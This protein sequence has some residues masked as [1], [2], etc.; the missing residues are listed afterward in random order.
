MT[1]AGARD[2]AALAGS[3]L[4]MAFAALICAV[5]A[6]AI[7][8]LVPANLLAIAMLFGSS[9]FPTPSGMSPLIDW[10]VLLWLPAALLVA[11]RNAVDAMALFTTPDLGGAARL[12]A[13]SLAI[14]L[15]FPLLW[16]VAL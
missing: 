12:A 10:L 8:L 5:S 15:S 14:L 1:R 11:V 3:L 9:G 4:I 13:W 6:G 2:A 7:I 16:G